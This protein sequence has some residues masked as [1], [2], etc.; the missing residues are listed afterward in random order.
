MH[1]NRPPSKRQEQSTESR[2]RRQKKRRQ[3]ILELRNAVALVVI[4]Y[5]GTSVIN[6]YLAS[7]YLPRHLDGKSNSATRFGSPFLLQRHDNIEKPGDTIHEINR[8][9]EYFSQAGVELDEESLRKLPSW[10]QIEYLFGEKPVLLGLDRCEDFRKNVPPLRRMLGSAGMF[11]S[12]TNLVTRLLKENCVIPERYKKYGPDASKEAFGIRWQC[13]WGKHTPA[14]F[15][16]NH[17]APKN[18]NINKDDCLPIVTVRNPFDWMPSM[19]RHPYTARWARRESGKSGELCPHLVQSDTPKKALVGVEVKL[20]E[21]WLHYDSLA[22]LWNEWY[23][24]YYKEATFPFLIVRFEDLTFRQFETTKIICECAGG[25]V[26]PL[27]S[28]KYIINSAKQGPGHGKEEDRTG[29]VKAWIK[30]GKPYDMKAGFSEADWKASKELLSKD[31][32]DKL[33]YRY[34]QS[35]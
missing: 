9:L 33:G 30:Y 2:M 16:Y 35:G 29:M 14:N 28:F 8:V 26:K 4:V 19:C 7:Y 20:A 27:S 10:E 22:H 13:P 6:F 25:Y 12:G 23:A 31:F 21:K 1:P 24:K 11:N 17:T 15:K 3:S 18:E 34:P 5:T 32:F